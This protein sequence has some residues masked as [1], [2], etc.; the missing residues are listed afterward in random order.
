MTGYVALLLPCSDGFFQRP[1]DC[2]YSP[3]AGIALNPQYWK[4]EWTQRGSAATKD[5]SWDACA[6]YWHTSSLKTN[7]GIARNPNTRHC[8][9]TTPTRWGLFIRR[10]FF[11]GRVE[12]A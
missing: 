6:F 1:G 8:E 10:N 12:R 5:F 11:V 7:M 4:H 9:R 3:N 2:F